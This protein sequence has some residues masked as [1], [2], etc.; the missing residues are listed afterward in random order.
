MKYLKTHKQYN[1]GIKSAVA[2]LGLA[3]GVLST[4]LSTANP[5][6]IN[7]EQTMP[8]DGTQVYK[9]LVD[10]SE[11]RITKD[12][13]LILIL[14]ELKKNVNSRDPN[15][16]VDLFN[17]LSVHLKKEYN[18]EFKEQDISK[19]DQ[20]KIDE[21]KTTEDSI[22]LFT[23]LGW[24]GSICLAACGVPQAWM[25]YKDKHSHGISWAFLI[26]WAVGELL[27]MAYVYDKLDLP[28]LVNYSVNILILGVI[29]YFKVRPSGEMVES[30]G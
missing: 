29:I 15:K 24:L 25:S 8:E 13:A 1:E 5:N 9:R 4:N 2:G 18:Y 3:A 11:K 10:L 26:L 14:D 28:M 20:S 21:L 23:I 27:A 7:I 19:L 16:Y 6:T 12:T 17:K 30:I 22:G